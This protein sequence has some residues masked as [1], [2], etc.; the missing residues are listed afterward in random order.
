MLLKLR[1][2]FDHEDYLQE[3]IDRDSRFVAP[4]VLVS[5]L[6]DLSRLSLKEQG[7]EAVAV[8]AVVPLT[9]ETAV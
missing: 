6:D 8:A 2:A 3:A 1:V 9:D 4:R 5:I 7:E